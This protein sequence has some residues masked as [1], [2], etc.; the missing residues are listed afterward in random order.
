[1][2]HVPCSIILC[3]SWAMRL[4]R[5][6][7]ML[8]RLSLT[9]QLASCRTWVV[10]QNRLVWK[11]GGKRRTRQLFIAHMDPFKP[12][13]LLKKALFEMVTQNLICTC[14]VHVFFV[15]S[16]CK[17]LGDWNFTVRV[18]ILQPKS[19]RFVNLLISTWVCLPIVGSSITSNILTILYNSTHI[20]DLNS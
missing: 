10:F 15:S 20:W 19:C 8:R 6:W 1:M 13:W 16:V 9:C 2:M 14:R 5:G 7:F 18:R 12:M 4:F 17:Y 11:I 3:R